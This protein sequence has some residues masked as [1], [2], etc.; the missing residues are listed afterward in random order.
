MA[1]ST[2]PSITAKPASESDLSIQSLHP[3]P[4]PLPYSL[5]LPPTPLSTIQIL[6]TRPHVLSAY[7]LSF[8]QLVRRSLLGLDIFRPED[9]TQ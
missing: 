9:V 1:G 6:N 4:P 8:R 3:P 7:L 5:N 2:M